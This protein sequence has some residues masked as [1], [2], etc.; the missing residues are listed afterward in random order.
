MTEDRTLRPLERR[1]LQLIDEG[2]DDGEI[3]WRFRR[4]PDMIRRV[5]T[6]ARLPRSDGAPPT[7]TDV[8]RPLER[9]VLRWRD[10]GADYAEIASRFR[11]S[12]RFVRRVED[13]ALYKL[14]RG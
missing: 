1:V 8:L 3:A 6:L 9:R 2:V 12:P 13:L 7:A 10:L 5:V 14:G 4:S 11:R